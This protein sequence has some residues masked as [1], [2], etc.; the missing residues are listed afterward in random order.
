[1]AVEMQALRGAL[2][3]DLNAT[4][5]I[6]QDV[7]EKFTSVSQHL[8]VTESVFK[9][10]DAKVAQKDEV[11][12]LE[13]VLNGKVQALTELFNEFSKAT[14]DKVN[15]HNEDL[16]Q[17]IGK[18]N[19]INSGGPAPTSSGYNKN[20]KC[21]SEYKAIQNLKAFEGDREYFVQWNDKLLNAMSEARP[22]SRVLLKHLNKIWAQADPD[23]V[24]D[25]VIRNQVE[26]WENS[27]CI[28]EVSKKFL[29]THKEFHLKGYPIEELNQDLYYVLVEKTTGEAA[30]KV[31]AAIEGRGFNAYFSIY[32]WFVKTSGIAVQERSRKAMQPEPTVKE[33]KMMECIEAWEEDVKIVEMQ[34][35]D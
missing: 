1:M 28:D 10:L 7:A 2:N 17:A 22:G 19:T 31:K 6:S 23:K 15:K 14:A 18:V 3:L 11:K 16:I 32:W 21:I 25:T 24:T 20:N 29:G 30:V 13:D 8:E 4:V 34:G 12:K 26:E 35:S 33:E 27:T 5:G 9:A